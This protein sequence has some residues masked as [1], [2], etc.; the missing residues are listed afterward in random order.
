[1]RSSGWAL[2]LV[3]ALGG[4][5]WFSWLPFVDGKDKD[6]EKAKLKPAALVKF[7]PEVKV[8]SLWRARVGEGL[9]KKF[10][11]LPPKVLAD[12]IYAAD[13]YGSVQAHDRF[14]GK[15]LW[16][17]RVGK[18]P[19]GF[20]PFDRR[21]PSFVSGGVGAGGGMVLVATTAG[22]V[23][24]LS[25]SD[26]TEQ[27]RSD[28]GSEVLAAPVP[29]AGLVFVQTIDGRLLALEEED[30]T[31]RWSYAVQVPVLTLR[32]TATPVVADDVVFAGFSTG[33]VVALRT[34]NGEPIWEQRVMLPEGR[35]ELDRIV[36]ADTTPL[37][38]GNRMYVGAFQGRVLGLRPSD[39]S[40]LWEK[41]ISTF[42]DFAEGY[43]QVYV[44]DSGDVVTA[45]DERSADVSWTQDALARRKLSGPVAF[46]NYVVTGDLDG[47]LHVMAQSDGRF[48]A[49]RKLDG[50]GIRTT[51]IVADGTLYVLGNSGSLHAL[52]ILAE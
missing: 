4:C 8:R 1:M 17:V 48:L 46:S 5:S 36:D 15:R 27:W 12:R 16:R 19:G 9:G 49:R 3:V 11:R 28:V 13:G 7:T 18:T 44:I 34:D 45:V 22:E 35:S 47:Y 14:S 33:K 26:G 6:D 25:G 21:D 37:F 2:I 32:G 30:G 20:R 41:E 23:V 29:G 43:G 42:L 31:I 50:K 24:A 52:E 38:L 39:G 40:P 51:P 10:L